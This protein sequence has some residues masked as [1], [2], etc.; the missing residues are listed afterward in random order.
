MT[1][2]ISETA[3]SD[4]A[5]LLNKELGEKLSGFNILLDQDEFAKQGVKLNDLIDLVLSKTSLSK[6]FINIL[7]VNM[8]G[9]LFHAKA[10]SLLPNNFEVFDYHLEVEREFYESNSYLK[11]NYRVCMPYDRQMRRANFKKREQDQELKDPVYLRTIPCISKGILI[12]TSGNFTNRGMNNNFEIGYRSYQLKSLNLFFSKFCELKEKTDLNSFELRLEK[13]KVQNFGVNLIKMGAFFHRWEKDYSLLF[14][15]D[16]SEEEIQQSE[17]INKE[18][19]ADKYGEYISDTEKSLARDPI[20]LNAFFKK[21]PKPIPP[22]FW[23]EYSVETLLGIWVPRIVAE[24]ALEEL[25]KI[26]KFYKSEIKNRFSV[27]S[28]GRYETVLEEDIEKFRENN[29]ISNSK[30]NENA[31]QNWAL[32]VKGILTN[33]QLLKTYICRHEEVY[34]KFAH[35]EVNLAG[36]IY[37]RIFDM[38]CHLIRP[39]KITKCILETKGKSS[40]EALSTLEREFLSLAQRV[41]EVLQN[42]RLGDFGKIKRGES[43]FALFE[44][45]AI[46]LE[47]EEYSGFDFIE[48]IF[49]KIDKCKSVDGKKEIECLYYYLDSNQGKDLAYAPEIACLYP[50]DLLWSFKILNG[51]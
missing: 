14:R 32:K 37:E 7:P 15:L 40:V 2:Y 44:K 19:N 9:G 13:Y 27:E 51:K 4:I 34:I 18:I 35:G 20:G 8:T 45:P 47:N 46:G 1:C 11:R 38:N 24:P 49:C 39:K 17:K 41:K 10:Y 12:V 5:S 22:S 28:I 21:F 33:E 50:L 36:L 42:N 48:G 30:D 31:I 25:N 26:L 23:A 29:T 16:K 6:N 43:F 3:I